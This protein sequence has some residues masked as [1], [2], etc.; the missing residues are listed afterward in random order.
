MTIKSNATISG[1]INDENKACW[2]ELG[3]GGM[4]YVNNDQSCDR[5][6]M[7]DIGFLIHKPQTDKSLHYF[8]SLEVILTSW[9]TMLPFP[10]CLN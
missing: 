8:T 3:R 1:Y 10:Q 2:S 6:F 7:N 5:G 9:A 4:I